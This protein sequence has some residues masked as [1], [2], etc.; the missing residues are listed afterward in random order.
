MRLKM[1]NI[2]RQVLA[3][4]A[5][6]PA[7]LLSVSSCQKQ[8]ALHYSPEDLEMEILIKDYL[9]TDYSSSIGNVTI[10]SDKVV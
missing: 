10:T 8:E 6:L 4:A 9:E 7:A 1:P 5:V 3:A 2:I